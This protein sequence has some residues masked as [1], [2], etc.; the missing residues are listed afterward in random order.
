MSDN[1]VLKQMK[2]EELQILEVK[3]PE[4]SL[5]QVY[6]DYVFPRGSQ[7]GESCSKPCKAYKEIGRC[8]RHYKKLIENKERY[9]EHKDE[10]KE[11][12]KY[13]TYVK[14]GKKAQIQKIQEN[15]IPFVPQQENTVRYHDGKFY[16]EI[17]TRVEIPATGELLAQIQ[18]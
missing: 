3:V 18:K 6:C 4:L 11:G 10:Y 13:Y 14:E 9:K 12:G 5:K 1:I 8:Y 7:K 16:M 15:D 17:V 2:S